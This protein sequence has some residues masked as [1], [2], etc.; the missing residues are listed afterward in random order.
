MKF[1]K[2][3]GV[4]LEK[5]THQKIEIVRQWRN[6]PK[7][8]KYMEF[9]EEITPQMQEN[10]FNRINNDNNLYYIIQ[11]E[12]NDIGLINIKDLN[13]ELTEGESG[14]FIYEDKYLNRDI[15][16]R[17][18]LALFDYFF[19]EFNGKGLKSH[20]KED[21]PR[22]SRFAQ[23]LGFSLLDDSRTEYHLSKEEYENNKNRQRF[24]LREKK[25]QNKQSYE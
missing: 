16:Y 17:A 6:D 23:F 9:H 14:C 13:D 4:T 1:I 5:M 25:L 22:A 19:N 15:S 21:N 18:H 24:V 20:I 12:G 7:I 8:D 11:Y 10:W 2:K 3:Y